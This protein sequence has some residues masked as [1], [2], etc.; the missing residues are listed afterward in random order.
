MPVKLK[1]G[2]HEALSPAFGRSSMA[3]SRLAGVWLV[4]LSGGCGNGVPPGL[5]DLAPT[6]PKRLPLVPGLYVGRLDCTE[7][8]QMSEGGSWSDVDFR[9]DPLGVGESGLPKYNGVEVYVGMR[10]SGAFLGGEADVSVSSVDTFSDG[11]TVE[12][13]GNLNSDVDQCTLDVSESFKRVGDDGVRRTYT[14]T[15]FCSSN[16]RHSAFAE[17]CDGV[18]Y[19]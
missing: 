3:V 16:S 18:L 8:A 10:G 17:V 19:R 15:M 2:D 12:W 5:A 4:V 14:S 7:S 9:N 6:D 1:R 11:V 13:G